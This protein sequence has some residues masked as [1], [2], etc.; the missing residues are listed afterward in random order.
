MI[1][2]GK[3]VI[4]MED[5]IL[6][7]CWFCREFGQ[8]SISQPAPSFSLNFSSHPTRYPHENISA[9]SDSSPLQINSH[10]SIEKHWN[11]RSV[12]R[13]VAV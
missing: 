12:W 9:K 8:G 10:I 1:L 2:S 13:K 11:I 6:F 3:G 5:F 4:A 7:I